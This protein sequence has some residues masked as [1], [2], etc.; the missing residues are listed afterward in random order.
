MQN[1]SVKLEESGKASAKE[2]L[3]FFGEK[4][5]EAIE[6]VKEATTFAV[7][8]AVVGFGGG[9][10]VFHK[11]GAAGLAIRG[12]AY[13]IGFTAFTVTGTAA[14]ALTGLAVYGLKKLVLG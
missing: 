12:G 10:Y 6:N 1:L 13:P 7:G 11:T 3:I 4:M 2:D 8:G 14:G 5:L 9:A